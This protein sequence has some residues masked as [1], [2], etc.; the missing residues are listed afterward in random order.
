MLADDK[1]N[2][3]IKPASDLKTFL[4]PITECTQ[5]EH[6]VDF[7][8]ESDDETVA[9][10]E[11]LESSHGMLPPGEF[12]L[13]FGDDEFAPVVM[14]IDNG[15][16]DES[17]LPNVSSSDSGTITPVA[18]HQI[19]PVSSSHASPEREENEMVENTV[20]NGPEAPAASVASAFGPMAASVASTVSTFFYHAGRRI[21]RGGSEAE[22]MPGYTPPYLRP[23]P[24]PTP[25]AP[26][27]S[28]PPAPLAPVESQS[29]PPTPPRRPILPFFDD[30]DEALDDVIR[31]RVHSTPERVEPSSEIGFPSSLFTDETS[32]VRPTEGEAE[33]N[34]PS[35]FSASGEENFETVHEQPETETES[36]PEQS[37]HEPQLPS[38][39]PE[40][41][42]NEPQSPA[43][44]PQSD[45]TDPAELLGAAAPLP[46][47][48]PPPPPA[49]AP[50]RRTLREMRLLSDHNNPGLREDEGTVTSRLRPRPPRGENRDRWE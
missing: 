32:P 15:V 10:E 16:R 34:E 31:P 26:P 17:V 3:E 20:P 4:P 46:P 6:G 36:E 9:A 24:P 50:S 38:F 30:S 18:A 43:R 1:G 37:F 13:I 29:L 21:F 35:V 7:V 11:S 19:S 14:P 25:P 47:P 40:L 45:D 48:P 23:L 8:V 28:P 22:A 42:T 49:P 39:E 5:A 44:D 41:P 12:E 2:E 27:P 33:L